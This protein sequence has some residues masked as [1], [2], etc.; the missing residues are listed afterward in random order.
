VYVFDGWATPDHDVQA[1]LLSQ[2]PGAGW[3]ESQPRAG[4]AGCDD[5]VVGG[6][7]NGAV[8]LRPSSSS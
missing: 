4:G 3:L 8:V 2:V 6:G 5:L 7:P 1:R